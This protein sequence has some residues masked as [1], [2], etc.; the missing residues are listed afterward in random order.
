MQALCLMLLVAAMLPSC[1]ERVE[2]EAPVVN[3]EPEPVGLAFA[4][5]SPSGAKTRLADEIV[6]NAA[7]YR[8][9]S[10]FYSSHQK[11]GH[12]HHVCLEFGGRSPAGPG[13]FT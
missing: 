10:D 8:G 2:T 9:I 5:M 6:Q 4:A 7:P 3:E 13:P 12:H 1:S 11:G